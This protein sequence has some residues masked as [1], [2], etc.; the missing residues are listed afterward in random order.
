MLQT[1]M[2]VYLYASHGTERLTSTLHHAGI[3]ISRTQILI[4]IVHLAMEC[5]K[6]RKSIVMNY[7]VAVPFDNLNFN[8]GK[9]QE[10]LISRKAHSNLTTATVHILHDTPPSALDY[11]KELAEKRANGQWVKAHPKLLEA[12]NLVDGLNRH[13]RIDRMFTWHLVEVLVQGEPAFEYLKDA[14]GTTP[15]EV[16][17]IPLRKDEQYPLRA[18]D[19]DESSLEGIIDVMAGIDKQCGWTELVDDNQIR[20]FD[21]DLASVERA[22]GARTHRETER[23][24]TNLRTQLQHFLIRPGFFHL[25]MACAF[26]LH[27]IHLDKPVLRRFNESLFGYVQI[28][29]PGTSGTVASNPRFRQLHEMAGSVLAALGTDIWRLCAPDM[30]VNLWAA[31]RPSYDEVWEI[32]TRAKSKYIAQVSGNDG[33]YR[34]EDVVYRN[35]RLLLRDLILYDEISLAMNTGDIGRL[36]D[37]IKIWI[38]M[39]KGSGQIKYS[40]EM[41]QF[42]TDLEYNFPPDLAHAVRMGWLVNPTG[43]VGCWRGVDWVVEYNNLLTRNLFGKDASNLTVKRILEN[44]NL[45]MTFRQILL[46][47]DENY[48][49]ISRSIHH[50]NPDKAPT[51]SVL[52]DYMKLQRVNEDTVDRAGEYAEVPNAAA[53]GSR[54]ILTQPGEVQVLDEV[55]REMRLHEDDDVICA[56]NLRV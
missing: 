55:E 4:A 46:A 9:A 32:A 38:Y 30:D 18:M 12:G 35:Q 31:T 7:R 41:H 26:Y 43:K 25:K 19:A 33:G 54:K 15:G 50:T 52:C 48:Q 2:G 29:N 24:V 6:L 5:D 37:V 56:D 23:G 11:R 36:E 44:S 49:N 22:N 13:E 28:L 20:I 45:I 3:C 1:A 8:F 16:N 27:R 51:L 17:Q 42:L 47:F 53:V 21:G 14:H 39:W 40:K 10:T 34:G